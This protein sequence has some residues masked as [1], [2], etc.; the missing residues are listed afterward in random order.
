[1]NQDGDT[2]VLVLSSVQPLEVILRQ[3]DGSFKAVDGGAAGLA[4]KVEPRAITLGDLNGDGRA[5]LLVTRDTFARSAK[6]GLN[7]RSEVMDQINAPDVSASLLASVVVDL[8]ADGKP[9][10]LLVDG[11]ASKI[12]VMARDDQGVYRFSR[13]HPGVGD[14]TGSQ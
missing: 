4:D 14:L 10:L 6:L 8:D 12:H 13:S 11:Q 3:A 7:G 1:M 2:D 5:E 9:E